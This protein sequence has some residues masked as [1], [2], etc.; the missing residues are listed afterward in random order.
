MYYSSSLLIA[1]EDHRQMTVWNLSAK[2][3]SIVKKIIRY[4][5]IKNQFNDMNVYEYINYSYCEYELK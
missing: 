2:S 1:N 4:K 5:V 3:S